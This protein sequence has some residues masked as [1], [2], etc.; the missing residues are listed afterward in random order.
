MKMAETIPPLPLGE[1]SG[2]LEFAQCIRAGIDHAV[3]E[4][5]REMV[6]SDTNFEDWPLR[7]S[8]VIQ[9]LDAWAGPGH[10]LTLLAHRYDTVQRLH[11]RFVTW[12]IRW[13]HLIDCRVCRPIGAEV[14][15]SALWS[16]SWFLRRLDVERCRGVCT[17]EARPRVELK[18]LLDEYRKQSSPGF[19]ASTLGL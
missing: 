19:P 2:P 12:R 14:L 3:Q 9:A 7:E 13:D 1:F 5:W 6:W 11:A 16:P 15:P 4:G 18:Q 17:D 8:A 10:R